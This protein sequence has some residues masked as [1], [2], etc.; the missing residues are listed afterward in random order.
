M[1]ILVHHIWLAII[2]AHKV[3]VLVS[4]A[5]VIEWTS[6]ASLRLGVPRVESSTH[7]L[8][9]AVSTT[10]HSSSSVPLVLEHL[11]VTHLMSPI[12]RIIVNTTVTAAMTA[13]MATPGHV[14]WESLLVPIH[15][16]LL[17]SIT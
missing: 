13:T 2:T 10:I 3:V 11:L 7:S 8:L 17:H 15:A 14:P 16:M 4:V 9:I 6:L 12:L 5:V 1:H